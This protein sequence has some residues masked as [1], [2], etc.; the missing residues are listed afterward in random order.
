MAL[1]LT[2]SLLPAAAL[3]EDWEFTIA[4]GVLTRYNGFGGDVIIPDGVTSIG[5]NVFSRC[6]ITS[7]TIP[8]GVTSMENHAFQNCASLASVN[9]P[10]SA[11]GI[12]ISAFFAAPA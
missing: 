3:A 7:V 4:N 9:I 8:S 6:S 5:D 11:T 12:G 1:V 2:L 10:S